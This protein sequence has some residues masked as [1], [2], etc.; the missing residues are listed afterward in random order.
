MIISDKVELTGSCGNRLTPDDN[1]VVSATSPLGKIP[2]ANQ[3]LLW[4]LGSNPVEETNEY[5]R[6][7]CLATVIPT[8]PPCLLHTKIYLESTWWYWTLISRWNEMWWISWYPKHWISATNNVKQL[9]YNTLHTISRWRWICRQKNFKAGRRVY[10][11]T[12]TYI[13]SF[14]IFSI[15]GIKVLS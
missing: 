10:I 3:T 15:S 14:F 4:S 6:D 5:A 9:L 2:S 1:L 12:L 7:I 8:S 11:S 13:G